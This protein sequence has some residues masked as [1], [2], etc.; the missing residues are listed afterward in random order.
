MREVT[1]FSRILEMKLGFEFKRKLW[2]Y[3]WIKMFF[4]E[5]AGK[6]LFE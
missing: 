4:L 1:T 3:Q 6:S 5:K 2:R